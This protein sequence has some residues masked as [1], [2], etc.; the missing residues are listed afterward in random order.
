MGPAENDTG[1]LRDA[2]TGALAMADAQQNYL[3]AAL[4]AECLDELDRRWARRA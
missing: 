3:I 2:I 4:L 1:A